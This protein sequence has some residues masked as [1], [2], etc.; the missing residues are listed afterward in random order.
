MALEQETKQVEQQLADKVTIVLARTTHPGNIGAVARAMKNMG[1]F[2]IKLVKPSPANEQDAAGNQIQVPANQAHEAIRRASGAHDLLEACEIYETLEAA[3]ADE[4]VVIGA[5]ARTRKMPWRLINPRQTA[6]IVLSSVV[7]IKNDATVSMEPQNV[8]LLFGNEA[9]GLSNEE[10]QRC[11]YHVNIPAVESFASLNL[12]MAV[13][14]VCYEV[15]MSLLSYLAGTNCSN[16]SSLDNA[17][18]GPTNESSSENA[19]SQAEAVS[20]SVGGQ[21][22]APQAQKDEIALEVSA[23]AS[24]KEFE[25]LMQHLEDVLVEI[26]F[27][28]PNNP[29][30]LMPKL[31]RLYARS[32]LEKVEV[33]ILRGILKATSKHL[34]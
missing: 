28:D 2:R 33:N 34:K 22:S 13:Q 7:P 27:L 5:S 15:R 14:L 21:L 9:S 32:G 19:S 29:R 3:L 12:A 18:I 6:D 30:Q 26:G 24:G 1:L 23:L 10:L 11:H 4:H 25:G 31:R 8:A 16:P 20:A 17:K